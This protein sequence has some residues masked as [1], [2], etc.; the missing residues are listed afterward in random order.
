MGNYMNWTLLKPTQVK[1][2]RAA[3]QG[4]SSILDE[5]GEP[6]PKGLKESGF[7]YLPLILP[8]DK[9]VEQGLINYF[10]SCEPVP[11]WQI[12]GYVLDADNNDDDTDAYEAHRL[13]PGDIE[14]GPRDL[15][16]YWRVLSN[17][18]LDCVLFLY[19]D[20]YAI[21]CLRGGVCDELNS[22]QLELYRDFKNNGNQPGLEC[23]R[24]V[25]VKYPIA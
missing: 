15:S 4:V 19:P 11:I 24:D 22:L 6:D 17:D 5:N 20:D 13:E 8:L 25:L 10:N 16:A 2:I 14:F 9:K 1:T 7:V 12:A 23:L 3:F 18:Q 21:A